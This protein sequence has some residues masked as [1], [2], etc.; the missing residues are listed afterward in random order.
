MNGAKV[1]CRQEATL[2][3][4]FDSS[5]QIICEKFTANPLLG[6]VSRRA[7]THSSEK[8]FSLWQQHAPFRYAIPIVGVTGAVVGTCLLGST[9]KYTPNLFFCAVVLSSWLGG[10]GAGTFSILLSVLALD[11]YFLP[12]I[13]ALGLSLEEMPDMILFV[14][15]GLFV[16]W[17]NRQG[18]Q[19]KKSISEARDER[20]SAFN[21]KNH[22][23][24]NTSDLLRVDHSSG[25]LANGKLNQE[26]SDGKDMKK[27]SRVPDLIAKEVRA[28][29][30]LR[31]ELYT[32]EPSPDK[33]QV[34]SLNGSR[35]PLRTPLTHDPARD[36]VFC[37]HGDYWTIVYESQTTWL[38][39]T[40]GLESLAC[41]LAHPGREFHV[42]ELVGTVSPDIGPDPWCAEQDGR[43]MGSVGLQDAGPILDAHA[44][45]EYKFRLAELRAELEDAEHF[46]DFDR[47]EKIQRESNVITEQLA[48]AVGFR[49]RNRRAASQAERAHSTVTKRIRGSINKIAQ[50]TPSLGRHLAASVRTGYFCAY[51]PDPDSSF[52]W[53]L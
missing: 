5:I 1:I 20:N 40:R 33:R 32:G 41:L 52:R 30:E 42:A 35:K 11:Y 14:T 6:M 49:G 26:P 34:L 19:A 46:N 47:A 2:K 51:N 27:F 31:R 53:K 38:K 15:A 4:C 12:P 39:A 45:A 9:I 23:R 16:N 3:S 50:N 17:V 10:V 36:C 25:E 21:E 13:Y 44:K 18:D 29:E 28:D 48:Q 7:A 37:R 22:E 43:Q 24:G 8:T